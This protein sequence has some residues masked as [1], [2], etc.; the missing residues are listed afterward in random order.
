MCTVL[1][2]RKP[3]PMPRRTSRPAGRDPSP[4]ARQSLP[5]WT[6][7]PVNLQLFEDRRTFHPQGFTRPVFTTQRPAGRIVQKW[8]PRSRLK[9]V[10]Q[11]SF[12][13]PEKVTLCVRRKRRKEVLF[14]K[15]KAGKTG[16][17]KPRR[18]YW[19]SI[20]CKR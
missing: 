7:I 18:N 5:R 11:L 9:G 15:K 3:L 19:S 4:I 6:S 2:D 14:A 17:R 20:S 8:H 13:I 12:A 10:A 1:G 16:Q